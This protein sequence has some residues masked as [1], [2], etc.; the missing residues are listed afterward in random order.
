LGGPKQ[1]EGANEDAQQIQNPAPGVRKKLL[2]LAEIGTPEHPV[3]LGFQRALL[4]R[5]AIERP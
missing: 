1:E 2:K 4:H 3:A 5:I